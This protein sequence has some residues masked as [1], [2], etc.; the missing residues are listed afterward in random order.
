MAVRRAVAHGRGAGRP[1]M[2]ATD[3]VGVVHRLDDNQTSCGQDA[4]G[5]S[6]HVTDAQRAGLVIFCPVCDW[7]KGS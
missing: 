7:G 1:V 4:T 6:R 3:P 2:T 5:W